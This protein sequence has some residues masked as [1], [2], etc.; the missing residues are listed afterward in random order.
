MDSYAIV[1]ASRQ[2]LAAVPA[3]EQAAAGLIP[4]EDLPL[5]LRFL[6]TSPDVLV[7]AQQDGRI[8]MALGADQVPVG[9]AY[10]VVMAGEAHLDE[11]NVH[12]RHGRRGLGK[13]LVQAVID[14]SKASGFAALTLITFHHLP[15]N[16]PFYAKLGFE[17][18]P[19]EL[20]IPEHRE[21]IEAE[22][23]AGINAAD[24]I[25]MRLKLS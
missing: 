16:A 10:A 23:D 2:H 19:P 14:W 1:P 20:V 25:V 13:R 5:A 18:V 22:A 17:I 3:I 6:V 12:P 9:F 8:W 21:L 15:W 24:R 11:T 7:E 4:E